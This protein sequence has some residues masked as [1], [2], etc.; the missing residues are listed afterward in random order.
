MVYEPVFK[1]VGTVAEELTEFKNTLGLSNWDFANAFGLAEITIQ[2]V[3]QGITKDP[4]ILRL[5]HY[6]ITEPQIALSQLE[7]TGKKVHAQ[8]RT[9]IYRHFRK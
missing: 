7:L 6:Y 8:T 1:Q 4:N 9:K 2:K 5:I 3:E